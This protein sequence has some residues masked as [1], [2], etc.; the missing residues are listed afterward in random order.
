MAL[1]LMLIQLPALRQRD[2]LPTTLLLR[3]PILTQ[4]N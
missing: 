1:V 4:I 3:A 2:Y